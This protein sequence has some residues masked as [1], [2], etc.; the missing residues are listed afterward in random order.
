MKANWRFE[1]GI[2]DSIRAWLTRALEPAVGKWFRDA[3]AEVRNR[4]DKHGENRMSMTHNGISLPEIST[5][6][7]V[8]L[9]ESRL[10]LSACNE[11]LRKSG[12][13]VARESQR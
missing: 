10:L 13:P 5:I 6:V 8:N 2:D 4:L 7:P 9:P 3:Y 12:L 1:E 11:F